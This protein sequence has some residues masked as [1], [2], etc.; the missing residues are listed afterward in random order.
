MKRNIYINVICV[1]VIITANFFTTPVYAKNTTDIK[2]GSIYALET[3][4]PDT[5]TKTIQGLIDKTGVGEECR[6]PE[7]I[8]SV[9]G[10]SITRPII[11]NG[12]GRA[13]LIYNGD[14]RDQAYKPNEQAY[15]F[16]IWSNDVIIEGFRFENL[17]PSENISIAHF[18]GDNLE[19]RN[20][21][22][23]IG[24][25]CAGI[26]S[27]AAAKNCIIERN[28]FT[29]DFGRRSFPM[30]QLSG[31][32]GGVR[33]KNNSLEGDVPDM[34]SDSFLSNFLALESRDAVVADNEFIY[35]GPVN[36]ED[37]GGYEDS[38]TPIAREAFAELTKSHIDDIN[39]WNRS[40]GDK[41]N[42]DTKDGFSPVVI[43]I[44]GV[45][46]VVLIGTRYKVQGTRYKKMPT[47]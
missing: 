44:I 23:N 1:S 38:G 2:S 41:S 10:L 30:I 33:I 42:P 46:Q 32:S 5:H 19:I 25:T 37:L 24:Q 18:Y 7:G 3:N 40:I 36:S 34:I 9:S 43:G 15:T 6:I 14:L 45:L 12:G 11:L 47:T 4:M 21:T 31:T 13:T 22:F 26:V 27:R 28:R 39:P 20:N 17:Q 29:A 8:Y 35:T 16:A